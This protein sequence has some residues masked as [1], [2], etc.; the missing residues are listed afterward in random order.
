[1]RIEDTP[2]Y[3]YLPK[4]REYGGQTFARIDVETGKIIMAEYSTLERPP[5]DL[6]ENQVAMFVDGDWETVADYRGRKFFR[7]DGSIAQ[8]QDIGESPDES[9][10][11]EKPE[12]KPL[13]DAEIL[14]GIKYEARLRISA[15]GHDWMALR[16]VTTGIPVPEY[17]KAQAELIRN[18][19]D[20]LEQQL[21]QDF[22]NDKHWPQVTTA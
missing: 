10:T 21:P 16:E 17:V 2:I 12:E 14:S 18:A 6:A 11:A 8:I 5:Q 7:P 22:T 9:W 1:M 15:S 3:H 13:T 19:S 20:I 4:T